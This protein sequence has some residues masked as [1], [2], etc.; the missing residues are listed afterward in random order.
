MILYHKSRFYT[1]NHDF[2]LKFFR[3]VC[4]VS[5]E[6]REFLVFKITIL[7]YSNK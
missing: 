7:Y 1:T 4:S 2:I 3:C 6:F 5:N